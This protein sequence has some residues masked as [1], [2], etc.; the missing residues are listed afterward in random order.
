MIDGSGTV[1]AE[2]DP[3]AI[4]QYAAVL[5]KVDSTFREM[6]CTGRQIG[7]RVVHRFDDLLAQPFCIPA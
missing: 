4:L 6:E 2:T 3:F 1:N 7:D 5:G